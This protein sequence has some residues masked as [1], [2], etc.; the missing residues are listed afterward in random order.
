M[1]QKANE[2]Q[3]KLIRGINQNDPK[4]LRAIYKENFQKIANMV[5]NFHNVYLDADDIF[6]DGLTQAVINVKNGK[7][8]GDSLFSTYLF[9]ICRNIC[10]KEYNKQKGIYSVPIQ[11]SE[12][13][14]DDDYFDN[15]KIV[16]ELKNKLQEECKKIIDLRFG[17]GSIEMNKEEL[18]YEAIAEKMNILPD[19]A[20]Q[21]FKRCMSKLLELVN[22]TKLMQ[23][24]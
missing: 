16:L 10:L 18:R 14:T 21:K 24:F 19:N 7:F 1:V 8:N 2:D 13:E 4:I 3:L 6:Q 9:G 12:D 23:N 5:H 22:Q 17:I 20:R 11:D 15:I